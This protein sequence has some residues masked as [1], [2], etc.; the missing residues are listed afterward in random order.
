MSGEADSN[1]EGIAR[2]TG[3]KTECLINCGVSD[4]HKYKPLDFAQLSQ[5]N[6]EIHSDEDKLRTP[7]INNCKITANNTRRRTGYQESPMK[8]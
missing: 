2:I 6:F 7:H 8:H 5:A 4:C 1:E 3:A